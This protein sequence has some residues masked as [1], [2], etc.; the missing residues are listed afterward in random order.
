MAT[1]PMA[2]VLASFTDFHVRDPVSLNAL[3]LSRSFPVGQ[4]TAHLSPS[5]CAWRN[6]SVR[7]LAPVLR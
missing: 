4:A 1:Q 7:P 3:W 2:A 5:D 6:T